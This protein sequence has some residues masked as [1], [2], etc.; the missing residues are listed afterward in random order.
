MPA[1]EPATS[2]YR[3]LRSSR[4]ALARLAPLVRFGLFAVGV[5]VFLDQVQPLLSEAQFTWG[6]RRVMGV[7][8]LVTLGGFGLAG[9][10]AGRLLWASAELIEVFVDGAEAAVRAS[11]L[12]ESQLVPAL[13]R[14]AAALERSSGG[15][16]SEAGSPAAAAVRQAIREGLWGRAE[17]LL[18][19]LRR[20][21]PGSA[22]A[23]ALADE[24]ARATRAEAA[25]LRDRLNASMA[26]GDADRVIACRDALTH[27]LR[28]DALH[29]LDARVVRW[30][31]DTIR[32]RARSGQATPELAALA[33]RAADSFGDT[34]EGAS[35][36]AELPVLRRR[37]GLCG[38]CGAPYRGP[39][40]VCPACQAGPNPP[41]RPR[42]GRAAPRGRP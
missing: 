22:E 18:E 40:S 1:F 42:P 29:A 39:D 33:A 21:E 11:Y 10:V 31:T 8:A 15:R 27:H 30:L 32:D 7:V 38:S 17:R 12:I 28:G 34:P 37:A 14:T 9:W 35:L 6:E 25:D 20:D 24:L 23:D 5:S 13:N 26:V 36:L 19:A 41:A 16:A 2:R 3:S 4:H